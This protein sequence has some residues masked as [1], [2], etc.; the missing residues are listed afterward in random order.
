MLRLV[1]KL[2]PDVLLSRCKLVFG[3]SGRYIKQGGFFRRQRRCGCDLALAVSDA[4]VVLDGGAT[5]REALA[6][7]YLLSVVYFAALQ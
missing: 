6:V 4:A 7:S 3:G 5:L 2:S 1:N